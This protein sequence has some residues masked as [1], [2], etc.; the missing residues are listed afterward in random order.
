MCHIEDY[1]VRYCLLG[2]LLLSLGAQVTSARAETKEQVRQ[3][4]NELRMGWG[5]QL[6]ETLVWHNPTAVTTTMP[7]TYRQTYDEN[8]RY[9]QHY[10]LEYNRRHTYWFA[11][12]VMMDVSC[13]KWDRVTR[14]GR[15]A[16][17]SRSVNHDCYNIVLM[18]GMRFTYFQHPYVNLYSGLG[19]G[20]GLN[21]GTE[22][23][24]KGFHT[25]VG[26]AA[27]I[28]VLG[29]SANYNRWFCNMDLGGLYSIRD[30]N[31]IFLASSRMIS[32]GI[33]V[34]F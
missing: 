34:R 30:M 29:L 7:E 3:W 4:K 8:Y 26:M 27:Y 2:F 15:G 22:V 13:V 5:D 12:G 17:V 20:M 25:D 14:N 11:Y 21:T 6:F 23:N 16:E 19:L 33:G 1:I 31:T 10:W 9:F 32:V 24:G 28:C 18:P